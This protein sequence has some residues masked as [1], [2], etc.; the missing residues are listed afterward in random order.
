MKFL[1]YQDELVDSLWFVAACAVF[2]HLISTYCGKMKLDKCGQFIQIMCLL[3]ADWLSQGSI[4][5]V[6]ITKD[7]QQAVC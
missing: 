7:R 2:L 6:K 5:I 1:S 3:F 4:A